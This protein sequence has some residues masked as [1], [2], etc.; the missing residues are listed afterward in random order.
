MGRGRQLLAC[1]HCK[2]VLSAPRPKTWCSTV[3]TIS[4]LLFTVQLNYFAR[5]SSKKLRTLA[6][7]PK[8]ARVGL[9]TSYEAHIPDRGA[10]LC[11]QVHDDTFSSHH[12]NP[13][14][15]FA[16]NCILRHSSIALALL[17]SC[18]LR[19]WASCSCCLRLASS[20]CCL[21]RWAS[22]SCCWRIDWVTSSHCNTAPP[23]PHAPSRPPASPPRRP[24]SNGTHHERRASCPQPLHARCP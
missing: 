22:C 14:G 23:A 9:L 2:I 11:G 16:C 20:S 6:Q 8:D 4:T 10:S 7:G 17:V 13:N 21:R 3:F 24:A 19:R 5:K 1:A 12:N 15:P 18:C